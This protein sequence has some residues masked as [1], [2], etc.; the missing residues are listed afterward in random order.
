MFNA[1]RYVDNGNTLPGPVND[2]DMD[3][4]RWENEGGSP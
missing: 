4:D 2:D 3:L 1:L